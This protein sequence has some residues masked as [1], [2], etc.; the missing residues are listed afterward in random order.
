[1]R[2]TLL[3]LTVVGCALAVWPA[4]IRSQAPTRSDTA[5]YFSLLPSLDDLPAGSKL[6]IQDQREGTTFVRVF[7]VSGLGVTTGLRLFDTPD[8]AS[9]WYQRMVAMTPREF[10]AEVGEGLA[11]RGLSADSV[12]ADTLAL[13][14]GNRHACAIG[15]FY[16]VGGVFVMTQ[17]VVANSRYAVVFEVGGTGPD[18]EIIALTRR[19]AALA[20]QRIAGP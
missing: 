9:A 13:T 3:P 6:L 20:D 2:L 17:G 15:R 4:P 10:A 18:D 12:R 7:A 5:R 19:L 14:T 1:M 16:H 11:A 8:S